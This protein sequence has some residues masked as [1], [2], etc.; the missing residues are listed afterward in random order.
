MTKTTA[1]LFKSAVAA[2]D[3]DVVSTT[4]DTYLSEERLAPILASVVK[5]IEAL[6]SSSKTIRYIQEE[7]AREHGGQLACATIENNVKVIAELRRACGG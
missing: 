5:C 7:Y 3:N 2:D 4:N 6:E 1:E